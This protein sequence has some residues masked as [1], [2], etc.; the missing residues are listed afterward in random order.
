MVEAIHV[1]RT[2]CPFWES[3]LYELWDRDQPLIAANNYLRSNLTLSAGTLADKAYSLVWFFRF[4]KR[5]ELD[6]F[7]MTQH[8]L[9]PFILHFRNELLFRVRRP[10]SDSEIVKQSPANG[11][12]RT[13]GYLRAHNVL[14]EVGWLCEWWGLIKLRLSQGANGYRRS[15]WAGFRAGSKTLPDQFQIVIP[16][17]R[18]KF[19]ENHALEPAEVEAIWDYLTSEARPVRPSVLVKHPSGPKRGWSQSQATAWHRAQEEYRVRLAWF[20]RQQ[21]LW[22]VLIGSAMRRSEVPLLMIVDLQFQGEALWVSLRLRKSTESLG[23]AKTGPRTI[24]IGWDSRV[25]TAWQNWIRSRQVL[26]NKWTRTTGNPKHEMLL[27]NRNGGPLTVG[28]MDSLFASLNKRF[29][30]FGGGFLEE[31]FTLHPHAI[32]H[33]VESLFEEWNVP[34]DVRQRHLGHRNPET[35][36]LYGKVY[37]KTYME[38]LSNLRQ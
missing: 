21:M 22:A 18:R 17:A 19:R 1:V 3:T 11:T 28:G 26:M 33:T 7:D 38:F 25:I 20:H 4:M 29:N 32:R 13:F 23:R 37:Q 34:R 10:V 14:S 8:T 6:F 30:V 31:Q 24:F 16:K 5:N 12:A 35:T 2:Y 15:R 36:D 9:K 27:T